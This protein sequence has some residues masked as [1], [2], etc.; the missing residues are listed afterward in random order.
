MTAVSVIIPT[1]C[2]ASR[3]ASLLRAVRSAQDQ[4]GVLVR[5]LV[6]VNG[7]RVD[8]D[9]VGRVRGEPGVEI[10]CVAEPSA[11]GAVAFGRKCVET[12][13]FG[14]LD[15]DDVYLTGTLRTR[16]DI[17][18]TQPADVVVSDGYDALGRL[19]IGPRMD[20]IRRNPGLALLKHNWFASCAPL[21]R[22]R[23]VTLPF[24][25]N[26]RNY[27]EWTLLAFRLLEARR[28]FTFLEEPGY[29]LFDTPGS[30]SKLRTRSVIDAKVWVTESMWRLAGGADVRALARKHF[31]ESLHDAA[32]YCLGIGEWR[33]AWRYHVRSLTLGGWRYLP[34]TRHLLRPTRSG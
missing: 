2:E 24:F 25:E 6:I 12:E 30:A 3:A 34:F 14:A 23:T 27:L 21:F 32:D 9:L 17:L 1:T 15:D 18:K 11:P 28:T 26:R 20:E 7:H 8:P 10:H 33:L 22:T 31:R 4:A 16:V 19:T 5:I 29:R 13:F